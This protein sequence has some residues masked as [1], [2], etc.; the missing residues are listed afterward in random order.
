MKRFMPVVLMYAAICAFCAG[1]VV[2]PTSCTST[3]RTDTL[4]AAV[5]VAQGIQDVFLLWDAQHQKDIV[6]KAVNAAQAEVD[7]AAYRVIRDKLVAALD[8]AYQAIALASTE[9]DQP[10][11]DAAIA[12]A[13]AA[14]ADI[15]TL[16]SNATPTTL[17]PAVPPRAAKHH[18]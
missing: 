15:E 17:R 8:L 12:A 4:H 7:L 3:E 11:L 2:I 6:A 13:K 14:E 10:S 1:L 9:N 16:M 18:G 5:L